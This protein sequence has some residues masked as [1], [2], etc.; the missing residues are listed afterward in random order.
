MPSA[1]KV[2]PT[3]PERGY[4]FGLEVPATAPIPI[5]AANGRSSGRAVAW[6]IVSDDELAAAWNAQEA[7]SLLDRRHRSGRPMLAVDHHQVLG[8]RISAPGFGRHIVS[9][10]G[11]RVLSVLPNVTPWRW[12]RLL[13]AQVLPLAANLQGLEVLHASA[14]ELEGRAYAFVAPSGTGKTTVAA[15]LIARGASFVTD[16]VFAVETTDAG[17][18]AH[19]GA[20]VASIDPRELRAMSREGRNRLG[21]VV[22]RSS[23]KILVAVDPVPYAL[24][25]EGLFFLERDRSAT[26]VEIEEQGSPDP[27]LLLSSA[28]IPYLDDRQRLLR[29][30]DACARLAA[31]ARVFRVRVPGSRPAPAVASEVEH[32][33]RSAR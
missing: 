1:R 8:Y 23:F 21:V 12:Q 25:L 6:E 17:T 18:L 11:R 15:H 4:A 24:P 32:H 19:A 27:A 29:H 28:F 33:I 5:A 16:D 2:E 22:G 26:R 9:G 20:G 3:G 31:T 7:V 10:D 30:L 14:V 13:F